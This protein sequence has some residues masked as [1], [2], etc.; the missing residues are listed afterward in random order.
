[1]SYER[2]LA[3][4]E[5]S[6]DG[7]ERP[8]DEP[9]TRRWLLPIVPFALFALALATWSLGGPF[10]GGVAMTLFLGWLIYVGVERK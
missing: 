10:A 9:F 3:R 5:K 6:T 2:R 8:T 1:M 4:Y 7:R